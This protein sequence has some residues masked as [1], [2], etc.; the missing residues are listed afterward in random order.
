MTFCT[1]QII[2]SYFKHLD[3]QRNADNFTL[4]C[5]HQTTF[6]P[7]FKIQGNLFK[8]NL[9]LFVRGL[10]LKPTQIRQILRFFRIPGYEVY[11]YNVI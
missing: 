1:F 4:D 11:A 3:I 6:K 9:L 10:R 2:F 5:S 7:K 8:T